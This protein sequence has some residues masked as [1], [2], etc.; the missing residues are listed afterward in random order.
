[1]LPGLGIADI[2]S[3]PDEWSNYLF[4]SGSDTD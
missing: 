1:V 4:G 2:A 3:I